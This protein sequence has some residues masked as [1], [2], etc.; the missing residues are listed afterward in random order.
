MNRVENLYIRGYNYKEIYNILNTQVD[1]ESIEKY[2]TRL[3]VKYKHKKARFERIKDL[4][5]RGYNHKE[6]AKIM[7]DNTNTIRNYICR[8]YSKYREEHILNRKL[9]KD[10]KRALDSTN[11]SYI[12][13]SSFLKQNRQAYKYND[14]MNITFDESVNGVR[15]LDT[16]KTFY[17]VG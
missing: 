15:T 6:I 5:R 10:I 4:Y 13:N 11:N 9:N 2:I 8:N 7:I 17:N 16:P 14:N 1:L 12:S 3:N